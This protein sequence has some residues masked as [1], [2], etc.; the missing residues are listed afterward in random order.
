[1]LGRHL[2]AASLLTIGHSFIQDQCHKI[3]FNFRPNTADLIL[4]TVQ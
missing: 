3:I 1:M 4:K 2:G